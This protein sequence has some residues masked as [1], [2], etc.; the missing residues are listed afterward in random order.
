MKPVGKIRAVGESAVDVV[1]AIN[2]L[3][4]VHVTQAFGRV[5]F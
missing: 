2:D 5:G 4:A 1:L 3:D